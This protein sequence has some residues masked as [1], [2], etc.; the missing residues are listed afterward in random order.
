M[1][2]KGSEMRE[3]EERH[4]D[5]LRS[6]GHCWWWCHLGVVSIMVVHTEIDHS[7]AQYPT[8]RRERK[9][10]RVG[11]QE[12]IWDEREDFEMIS[13]LG[14]ILGCL[15][16]VLLHF[17]MWRSLQSHLSLISSSLLTN[18]M[19]VYG[20]KVVI[21]TDW[22]VFLRLYCCV[23]FGFGVGFMCLFPKKIL[24][25]FKEISVIG[26]ILNLGFSRFARESLMLSSC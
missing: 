22:M 21:L 15:W 26:W 20:V 5:F 17:S 3:K 6:S 12:R 24:G 14:W 11:V 25:L 9:H 13:Y 23:V 4:R 2:D 16:A 10:L 8:A 19:V 18:W 7:W 1:R